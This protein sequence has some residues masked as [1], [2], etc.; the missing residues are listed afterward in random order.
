MPVLRLE[1]RETAVT[2]REGTVAKV[3]PR[4]APL[5]VL[6]LAPAALT[7]QALRPVQFLP[8]AHSR[9]VLV[10]VP[11]AQ[12]CSTLRRRLDRRLDFEPVLVPAPILLDPRRLAALLELV[13]LVSGACLHL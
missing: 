10:P 12:L 7:R 11:V 6:L 1:A 13:P 9:L 3:V 4:P 8:E 5:V 2:R